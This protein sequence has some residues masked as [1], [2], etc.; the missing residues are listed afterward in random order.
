MPH[1]PTE[2]LQL[3]D[4]PLLAGAWTEQGAG[5]VGCQGGSRF[6][7][8]LQHHFHRGWVEVMFEG[9]LLGEGG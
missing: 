4:G 1:P 8:V 2:E 9:G 5:V 6:R 3:W 7:V